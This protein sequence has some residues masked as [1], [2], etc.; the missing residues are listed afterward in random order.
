M[1]AMRRSGWHKYGSVEAGRSA[2][3]DSICVNGER[4]FWRR[5]RAAVIP[6]TSHL[7][8]VFLLS[9]HDPERWFCVRRIDLY[10]GQILLET[11]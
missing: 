3:P 5:S 7:L 9:L 11:A 6:V 1:F 10:P 8:P 4:S 2:E